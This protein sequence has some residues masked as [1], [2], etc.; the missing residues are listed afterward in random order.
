MCRRLNSICW[1]LLWFAKDIHIHKHMWR[2]RSAVHPYRWTVDQP[3][4]RPKTESNEK[5]Y[6]FEIEMKKGWQTRIYFSLAHTRRMKSVEGAR[7]RGWW[8]ERKRVATYRRRRRRRWCLPH[9]NPIHFHLMV[10]HKF[11]SLWFS[12]FDISTNRTARKKSVKKHNINTRRVWAEEQQKRETRNMHTS[13]KRAKLFTEIIAV[14]LNV[15][16]CV[17]FFFGVAVIRLMF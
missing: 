14:T 11:S 13:P 7:D 17:W 8:R 9:C 15:C 16:E 2:V 4:N 5:I 3:S 12:F 1:L 6:Y 10:A